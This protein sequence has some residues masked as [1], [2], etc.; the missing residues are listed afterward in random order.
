MKTFLVGAAAAAA[1]IAPGVASADT[2]G[3]IDFTFEQT[4]YDNSFSDFD[5]YALGGGFAADVSHGLRL[6][7]DGRAVLQDFDG[8]SGDSS[9]GYAAA[10]L[11]GDLGG[12]NVGGFLG[13]VNYYGDAGTFLGAEARHAFGNFVADGSIGHAD[14][15]S[16]YDGTSYRLGGS[17]FFMPNFS[18]SGG[19][20]FTGIDSG[21][22]HDITEWKFGAAY[23]FTNN[24]ELYGA[25]I[26][27]ENDRSVSAD[28]EFE[29]FQIGMRLNFG[30]GTLQDNT[31]TGL[32]NSARQIS[33]TWARW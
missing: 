25:Y 14:F 33:E 13:I 23:Q 21:Q 16:G 27:S 29:T 7:L 26:D 19:Y 9:H 17:Y 6:Q 22:D 11:S 32:W 18:V 30:G 12:F 20:G 4:D 8:F 5:T 3:A 24:I 31:N 1:L 2:Q 15:D 10:H 28:Y